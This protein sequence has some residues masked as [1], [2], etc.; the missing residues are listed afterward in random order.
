MPDPTEAPLVS[1]VFR[2]RAGGASVVELRDYL[3]TTDVRTA[4]GR[5]WGIHSVRGLLRSRRYLGEL[6]HGEFVN[7]EAHEALIDEAT[8]QLAQP[9]QVRIPSRRSDPSL[10]G[11]ILRCAGCRRALQSNVRHSQTSLE[12]RMYLCNSRGPCPARAQITDAIVEPY[13]EA[14]FWQELPGIARTRLARESKRLEVEVE[15]RERELATYRDNPRIL[16]TLGGNRFAEGLATRIGHLERAQVQ[17]ARAQAK[18]PA[19]PAPA[20]L[21]DE[22]WS[23]TISDR[24]SAIWEVI[25]AAFL[26]RGAGKVGDRVFVCR[27]GMAPADLPPPNPRH[28]IATKPFDPPARLRPLVLR[29]ADHEWSS[30]EL[31]IALAP[32]LEGLE[33][34]PSFREFQG[35]GLGLLYRQVQL[36][37]GP[38]H[39]ARMAGLPI[40]AG[41]KVR[42]YT[43]PRVRD[44][45]T[46]YVAGRTDWPTVRQFRADG[47][48]NL[49]V[50]VNAFGGPEHWAREMGVTLGHDQRI[51]ERW[52]YQ[53]IKA[54]LA[55]FTE[56]RVEWPARREFKNAG[57][58]RLYTAIA[59][60]QARERLAEQ[61]G[62][63]LQPGIVGYNQRWN[64][65]AIRSAL[66]PFLQ[67]RKTWPTVREFRTAG[68]A[69]L[70]HAIS[71]PRSR[72]EAWATA[73]NLKPPRRPPGLASHRRSRGGDELAMGE[74]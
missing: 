10:L 55:E 61:L 67:G 15:R 66:D 14:L 6:Q 63:Y 27:R 21:R 48:N 17:L 11:G 53:R 4:A 33:R 45:L 71:T 2:R 38:R 5:E 22:W 43:E 39:V 56:S 12:T 47:R 36:H 40:A 32:L 44:E 29:D 41:E 57:L 42:G 23:M 72:R 8:W 69:A 9:S 65:P 28:P 70:H 1:Q 19:L 58:L 7:P 34:W 50:A 62:L 64:E 30:T 13:L 16:A 59:S 49:R 26:R 31:C 25:D 18:R 24:R 68:L 20:A 3:A 60:H 35:A 74:T 37:G 51:K 52:S 73:Y 54:E 46:H